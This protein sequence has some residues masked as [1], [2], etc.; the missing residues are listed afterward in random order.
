MAAC[1]IIRTLRRIIEQYPDIGK[2][3]SSGTRFKSLSVAPPTAMGKYAENISQHASLIVLDEPA[4]HAH[5]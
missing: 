4:G 3:C 1:A 2:V 5:V